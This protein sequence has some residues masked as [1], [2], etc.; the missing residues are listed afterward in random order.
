MSSQL[1]GPVGLPTLA[2]AKRIPTLIVNINH[3]FFGPT[4]FIIEVFP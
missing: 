3:P 2:G 4:F 1:K